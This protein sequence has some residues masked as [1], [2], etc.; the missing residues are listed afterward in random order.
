MLTQ[1]GDEDIIVYVGE[2]YSDRCPAQFA[3]FVF[4]KDELQKFCQEKN[5][6]YFLY[7]S[8]DDVVERV[9]DILSRKRPKKR[10]EADMKRREAFSCE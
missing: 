10:R 8:F 9:K 2:G 1:A 6:S 3:D 7:N 4:A 5:I